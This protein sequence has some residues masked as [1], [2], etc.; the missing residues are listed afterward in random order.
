MEKLKVE[1]NKIMN[2]SGEEVIIK[3]ININSPGMLKYEENHDFLNDIKEIKKLGANAVRIPISPAYF[4]S[5]ENYL[6]EIL[7]PIV[8]LTHDLNIYCCLD[9]H[10]QGNP[11][12]N[13]TRESSRFPDVGGDM[14]F[15]AN[16]EHAINF[17][18]KVSKRYGKENHLLFNIFSMPINIKKENWIKTSKELVDKVR[19]N[20]DNI[21]VVN[22]LNWSSDLSW[23]LENPID[24]ENIVYGICYYSLKEFE[25]FTPI[26]KV[27]EKYPIIFC[28]CGWTKEGYF[29]GTKED[30][31]EKLKNY[32]S[33]YNFSFFA[34]AYHPTRQPPILKSWNP[35][36]L[37]E[38]GEFLK[39]ELLN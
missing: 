35:N 19:K 34:W 4:Q 15:D 3:G 2:E 24:S 28:E 16:K 7:D 6:E 9:W 18:E 22:G 10:A 5:K 17:L 37:T 25:N 8:N 32:V 36:D 30:Y 23:T 26:L 33:N 39:E 31:G 20:S 21:I 1:K 12:K 27:R 11:Y 14:V 38:W 29:K 13:I